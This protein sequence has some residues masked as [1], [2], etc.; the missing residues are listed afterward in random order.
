MRHALL[1]AVFL[2][3]CTDFETLDRGVCGNGLIEAGEDCDSGD[4]S[5]V[6]C[7]V[8][9]DE[10]ADCPTGA[11]ACGTDGLC[12]APGGTL[13]PPTSAGPFQVNDYRI[14]DIGGDGTGDVVGSSRTSIVVK[15]G[16]PSGLLGK[17]TSIVTP[18]QT[19]R[20]AFG[21]LDGDGSLDLTM[22]TADGL[23]SYTSPLGELTPLPVQSRLGETNANL[24]LSALYRVSNFALG[25][26]LTSADDRVLVAVFDLGNSTND[27]VV[28]PCGLNF[29]ASTFGE[30]AYHV[31]RLSADGDSATE[32]LF[33]ITAQTV[34]GGVRTCVMSITKT[35]TTKAAITD[36]TPIAAQSAN[37]GRPVL[38]DFDFDAD[39][40]PGLMTMNSAG[41][42]RYFDGSRAGLNCTLATTSTVFVPS[43]ATPGATLVGRFPLSPT[44]PLVVND[45]LVMSDGIY[46]QSVVGPFKVYASPRKI[47]RAEY[48][49][50]NGDGIVDGV[51]A[52]EGEDD[53]DVLFRTVDPGYQLVRLDTASR[54]TSLTIGD[55]DGNGIEDIAYTELLEEYQRLEVSFSTTDRPLEPVAVG[56][57]PNNISIVRLQIPD[58]L[59]PQGLA[60]DLAV[61]TLK[62][63]SRPTTVTLLH[64]SS[65]R[66]LLPYFDPTPPP[67]GPV[68]QKPHQ[69]RGVVVGE[70]VGGDA[71]AD[72][73]GV[74]VP[75]PGHPDNNA[76]TPIKA[77]VMRG[78]PVGPDGTVTQ[79]K[80][81]SGV[82]DCMRTT[83]PDGLC[84]DD[85]FYLP[86][87]AKDHDVVLMFDRT[88]AVG[89]VD[90][91]SVN[92]ALPVGPPP[93]G[94]VSVPNAGFRNAFTA[95]LDGDG[96]EDVVAVFGK[97]ESSNWSLR[98]CL[99]TG[100][101][102]NCFSHD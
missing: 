77:W 102:F 14:T 67:T 12:H 9:C 89:M 24:E 15:P 80:P 31:N 76:S 61:L 43:N 97:P 56:A 1:L 11:Y 7:A 93:N 65:Q 54:I 57:F 85:A 68:L 13:A 17:G 46:A 21:D 86:W 16:D 75:L 44:I 10:A 37:T 40:C 45:A 41:A 83:T 101:G 78:T 32:V 74:G 81:L 47:A 58:S 69:F 94:T 19:G 26:I 60:A 95:D 35:Q 36:I 96:Q 52:S 6:R 28:L 49:D 29:K 20:P 4:S 50:I 34:S 98:A 25:A 59:D 39:K 30:Y 33:A 64:G 22:T 90:P 99:N 51:V 62:T 8:T 18:F 23:V 38:I 42:L 5:C 73:A 82:A 87:R 3:G 72:I 70:F 27:E 92:A 63:G 84:V 66:T 55:Y 53:I 2:A 79:G 100:G 71:L 48:G 91:T 88:G